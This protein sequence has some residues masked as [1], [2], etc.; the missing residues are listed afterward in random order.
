MGLGVALSVSHLLLSQ[1]ICSSSHAVL[2][3]AHSRQQGR[4]ID[5]ESES[6]SPE[7]LVPPPRPSRAASCHPGKVLSLPTPQRNGLVLTATCSLGTSGKCESPGSHTLH[8]PLID[9]TTLQLVKHLLHA[10][11]RSFP[12]GRL[13]SF[14]RPLPLSLQ[15]PMRPAGNSVLC[16]PRHRVCKLDF[17]PSRR[18]SG[19]SHIKHGKSGVMVFLS[20]VAMFYWKPEKV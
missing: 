1:G 14:G 5:T 6:P 8:V 20:T 19:M 7:G 17:V 11:C 9:M 16:L 3:L 18:I 15:L 13:S 12:P 10:T 2:L 4:R